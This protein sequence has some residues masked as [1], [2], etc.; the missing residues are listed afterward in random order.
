M[1][2]GSAMALHAEIRK[3]VTPENPPAEAPA[4]QVDEQR[5]SYSLKEATMAK[6]ASMLK[7]A[8][9]MAFTWRQPRRSML[10]HS[11]CSES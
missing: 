4:L 10:Q 2:A 7:H 9:S 3:G 11:F 6:V 1:H 8:V 5:G